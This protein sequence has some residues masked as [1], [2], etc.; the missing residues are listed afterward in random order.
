MNQHC[1]MWRL[2]CQNNE[3]PKMICWTKKRKTKTLD[4]IVV[5]EF[6]SPNLV[7]IVFTTI[8]SFGVSLRCC[9][10][11]EMAGCRFKIG[12]LKK[13]S[14]CPCHKKLWN[15]VFFHLGCSSHEA[16]KFAQV[17]IYSWVH[18]CRLVGYLCKFGFSK[19]VLNPKWWYPQTYVIVCF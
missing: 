15:A 7:A 9:F 1:N 6:C 12:Q 10:Q 19:P 8:F 4:H 14:T 2:P 5:V 3:V 11:Q 16:V 17:Y 18:C 13:N